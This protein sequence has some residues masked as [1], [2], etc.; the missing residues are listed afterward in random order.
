MN[1]NL[2]SLRMLMSENNWDA[3]VIPVTDPHMSEY[4]PER[5]KS[6]SWVSGFTGSAGNGIVMMDFA[7]VWT[8]SRYF[9]QAEEQMQNTD[10]DLMKLRVQHAPEYVEWLADTL[11]E[12]STVAVVCSTMG[13]NIYQLFENAFSAKGIKIESVPDFWDSIWNERAEIP[14][15]TIFEHELKYA[16][17]SRTEK[18]NDIR[19]I[20]SEKECEAHIFST[21]DDIAWTLNLRGSDI[22]CNP[23][24]LS[25]L[26]IDQERAVLF[27]NLSCLTAKLKNKLEIEGVV[28]M[29]YNLLITFV[30]TL[31]ED[32]KILLDTRKTTVSLLKALPENARVMNV[33]NPAIGLKAI[34]N[35][36]EI[37]Y[38]KKSMEMDG[39][40]MVKFSIWLEENKGKS[41]IT[42]QTVVDKILEFRQIH[43]EFVEPSFSTIAGYKAHGALP[44]YSPNPES[45]LELDGTSLLLLDSGGQYF[46]GTTDITRVFSIGNITE[47]ERSD[48]TT[49]LKSLIALS[50]VRFPKGTS[51]ISLDVIARKPIW[52]AG[53]HYAHGTGHGV[54]YFLNVHEGPQAFGTGANA[55][56]TT[57]M[58]EGMV[59]T[60]EPGIYNKGRFGVRLENVIVTVADQKI[61]DLEFLKFETITLCPFEAEL[62][63]ESK[64]TKEEL[65]WLNEYHAMV[66]EKLSPFM[67]D[68]E[69]SWLENKTK[70][71]SFEN[72]FC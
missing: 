1:K 50:V 55:I 58:D 56:I 45:D 35:E 44:H 31:K 65:T 37:S 40:S 11:P 29:E 33:M 47:D 23:V 13:I 62:I 60:I 39:V 43:S 16:G 52:D 5:W 19:S 41:K 48:Y 32:I 69:K 17:K 9:I 26:F 36:T 46:G 10:F 14:A 22:N 42:E 3:V 59:T 34:K 20:I 66:F 12:G 61:N 63:D 28:L 72:Q 18:I 8:D 68:A 4:I 49:V 57:T 67:T 53:K 70:I 6:L 64:M 54:G 27:T 24:F 2:E 51:A 30:L 21:L 7:G 25:H 15:N 38:F 71:I